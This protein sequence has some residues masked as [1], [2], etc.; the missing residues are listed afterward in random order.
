MSTSRVNK[1][2]QGDSISL[3]DQGRLNEVWVVLLQACRDFYRKRT[4]LFSPAI[5][6]AENFIC[7]LGGNR[8]FEIASV[9]EKLRSL[10][11]QQCENLITYLN[12]ALMKKCNIKLDDLFATSSPPKP[13]H[14]S[15]D[16]QPRTR[17]QNQDHDESKETAIYPE[18][19]KSLMF[20]MDQES[21]V[22]F[23][24]QLDFMATIGSI[25]SPQQQASSDGDL[26]GADDED[27]F[28]LSDGEITP[29]N[30]SPR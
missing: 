25:A 6:W 30:F 15:L 22:V 19:V 27:I 10:Y 3:M 5:E 12:D 26:S 16:F 9:T 11:T 13:I 18:T 4:A 14:R 21:W 2:L 1:Q 17:V 29:S 24:K 20:S 7:E 8:E 23:P 28:E